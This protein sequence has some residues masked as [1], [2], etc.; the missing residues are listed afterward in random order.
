VGDD[1][2]VLGLVFHQVLVFNLKFGIL[3]FLFFEEIFSGLEL[4]GELSHCFF[5]FF[6]AGLKILNNDTLTL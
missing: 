1:S 2:L 5:L 6:E 4:S 3:Q